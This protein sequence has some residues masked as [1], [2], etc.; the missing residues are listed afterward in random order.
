MAVKPG[1]GQKGRSGNKPS[2]G[3]AF[4][5]AL[6]IAM[7][8]QHKGDPDGRKRIMVAAEQVAIAAADGD[9]DAITLVRDTLDGKPTVR[10]DLEATV[11]HTISA[12]PL[13]EAQWLEKYG[14]MNA[15]L[16]EHVDGD[17]G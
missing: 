8:V 10:V 13:S 14:G 6:R 4:E 1:C 3:K 9:L 16:I 12:E 7:N 11:R 17:N 15:A 2:G 5:H